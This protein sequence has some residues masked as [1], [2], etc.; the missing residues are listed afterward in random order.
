MW[1]PRRS[2]GPHRQTPVQLP[3]ES[4]RPSP[5]NEHGSDATRSISLATSFHKLGL[6][7]SEPEDF[8][9]VRD[10]A[11]G[12]LKTTPVGPSRHTD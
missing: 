11:T 4:A 10:K 5:S 2:F 12:A 7:A 9:G 8:C 6:I 1:V 3:C